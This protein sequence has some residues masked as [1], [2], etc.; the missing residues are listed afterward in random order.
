MKSRIALLIAVPLIVAVVLVLTF[1]G[2][3]S[4]YVVIAVL[5]V[6]YVI[7]SWANRRKFAK[8][9]QPQANTQK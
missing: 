2:F 9:E 4:S 3:F 7:V 1:L 8:Q 5:V 6:L